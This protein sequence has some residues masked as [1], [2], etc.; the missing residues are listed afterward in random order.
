[1]QFINGI[2]WKHPAPLGHQPVIGAAKLA[3]VI[4]HVLAAFEQP[5]VKGQAGVGRVA[6]NVDYFAL[7]ITAWISPVIWKLAGICQNV[8]QPALYVFLPGEYTEAGRPA[9]TTGPEQDVSIMG[10]SGAVSLSETDA[11][12]GWRCRTPEHYRPPP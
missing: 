2:R 7:G 1:M 8:R 6:L 4:A 3:E 10:Q 11:F 9:N 12:G 5:R